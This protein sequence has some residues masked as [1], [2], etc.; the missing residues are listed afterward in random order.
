M[1]PQAETSRALNEV[2]RRTRKRWRIRTYVLVIAAP[3]LL[4]QVAS[5]LY[6]RHRTMQDAESTAAH[7]ARHVTNIAAAL[8]ESE[9]NAMRADV[10][11]RSSASAG[12]FD[13]RCAAAVRGADGFVDGHVE[14]IDASGISQCSSASFTGRNPVEPVPW[15]S[16]V[17]GGSALIGPVT[18]PSTG[19]L[20]AVIGAPFDDGSGAVVRFLDLANFGADVAATFEQKNEFDV[21]IADGTHVITTADQ[22]QRW[23]GAPLDGTS[24]R[25]RAAAG[26]WPDLGGTER[27]YG[28]TD[29]GTTPWTVYVGVAH[30]HAVEVAADTADRELLLSSL[31]TVLVLLALFVLFRQIVYPISR[32]S[33][34]VRDAITGGTSEKLVAGG[35][36][37]VQE[38]STD[39]RALVSDRER[40]LAE[41]RRLGATNMAILDSAIDSVVTIDPTGT[42]V[43]FNPAAERT[44]GYQRAEVLGRQMSEVIIPERLRE[45]HHRGL[46]HYLATGDA[47]ILGQRLE[48]TA[49]RSDGSELSVELT[50]ALVDIAGS[51]LFTGTLRDL[52]E[53]VRAREELAATERRFQMILDNSPAIVHVKDLDGRYIFVNHQG[54]RTFGRPREEVIGKTDF[55]LLPAEL[56]EQYRLDDL[57]TLLDAVPSQRERPVLSAE[58]GDRTILSVKFPLIGPDGVPYAVAGISSDIT[59]MKRLDGE[60][61]VLQERLDQSQRLESLGQLAG[62]VAHDFNNLLAVILI[63]AKFVA[64]QTTGQVNADVEQIRAAAERAAALT[65]QLLVFGRRDRVNPQ[66]IDLADL[67]AGVLDVLARGI[68]PQIELVIDAAPDLPHVLADRGQME[69][70]LLNLAINARDA[71]PEGGTLTFSVDRDDVLD[72]ASARSTGQQV[73]LIVTDTGT[74]MEPEVIAR[75][76]EPFFTTKPPGQGTGLGLATV[77]GIITESGGTI[78]LS[79]TAG[80]GSTVR[81]ALPAADSVPAAGDPVAEV[82]PQGGGQTILVVDDEPALL[83][84]TVRMLE[85]HGY[86]V[87]SATSPDEALMRAEGES[88]HLLLTDFVMPKMNG[89]QLADHMRI[90]RPDL[91]VLLMS[92]YDHGLANSVPLGDETLPVLRKPF[93]EDELLTLVHEILLDRDDPADGSHHAPRI[94]FDAVDP[95]ST[96][97]LWALQQYFEELDQRFPEGFDPGGALSDGMVGF[98][99]A[100]AAFVVVHVNGAAVGCGGALRFDESTHEIKRMWVHPQWRGRG[101]AKRL[102]ADLEQRSMALGSSR[103]ILDTNSV[104]IEAITMYERNGYRTIERYNDNPYAKR[105]FEKV[106]EPTA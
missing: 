88:I 101:I 97:A 37:E 78:E 23:I 50:V 92:G 81:I 96:E 24:F 87:I 7:N 69:Q 66:P 49:M 84:V 30:E 100:S 36:R 22:P 58:S 55:D 56:A 62:G 94:T 16:E 45:S 42:I 80:R 72:G 98:T 25:G 86:D 82:V 13:E 31:L 89:A 38:L 40:E 39:F 76:F 93:S 104:L 103:V 79:S 85:Q 2:D 105:W 3:V 46:R 18:D 67:I 6:E 51:P 34:R 27:I 74:G 54:L 52:T 65:R 9:I 61:R 43:E 19:R 15:A 10:E 44:F 4:V 33:D 5:A 35:P 64:D 95:L 75:A 32:L 20:A 26:T 91:H 12:S 102:L 68:G 83:A 1:V 57:E 73:H 29:I 71:M 63:H 41:A 48:L 106:F 59:D 8:L 90:D 14:V 21:V 17:Q 28:R 77:Y 60:R 70:V 99:D 53:Q 11:R 47:A